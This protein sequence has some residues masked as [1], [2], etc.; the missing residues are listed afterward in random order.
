MT[1]YLNKTFSVP[2]GSDAYRNNWDKVFRGKQEDEP[3]NHEGTL[4][5]L[6]RVA[7]ED[8]LALGDIKQAIEA[9]YGQGRSPEQYA[10][11]LAYLARKR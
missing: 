6:E 1:Q 10:R 5:Q 8:E 4:E 3:V 9:L 2:L 11:T 7:T